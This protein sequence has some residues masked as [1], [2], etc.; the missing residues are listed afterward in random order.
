MEQLLAFINL[1]A[2]YCSGITQLNLHNNLQSRWYHFL[3]LQMRQWMFREVTCR[4]PNNGGSRIWTQVHLMSRSRALIIEQYTLWR[5]ICPAIALIAGKGLGDHVIPHLQWVSE[6]Q[7][8]RQE[9]KSHCELVAE[10]GLILPFHYAI[11]SFLKW[12]LKWVGKR[13]VTF[14][15][16][17]T[18]NLR[19]SWICSALLRSLHFPPWS[20]HS[21]D[22]WILGHSMSLYHASTPPSLSPLR[23]ISIAGEPKSPVKGNNHD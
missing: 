17:P 12:I 11:P 7:M 20:Q 21:W 19:I 5:E 1:L 3:Y 14:L 6:T 9:P 8:W 23:K 13:Y 10:L 18:C 22:L 16:L 15:V 2:E 4:R